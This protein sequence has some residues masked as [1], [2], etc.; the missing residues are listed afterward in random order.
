[1]SSFPKK[2]AGGFSQQKRSRC[3]LRVRPKQR[4]SGHPIRT[5]PMVFLSGGSEI[6]LI[7][8]E[9]EYHAAALPEK[10]LKN[11]STAD[12]VMAM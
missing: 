1:M 9:R 5:V 4:A 12:F 3:D 7:Q 10:I 6:R 2:A 11:P 8:E